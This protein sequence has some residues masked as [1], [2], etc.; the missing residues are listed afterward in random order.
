LRSF[1]RVV[2]EDYNVLAVR[3]RRCW[4]EE[5]VGQGECDWLVRFATTLAY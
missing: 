1:R 4:G 2:S 3:K 5:V